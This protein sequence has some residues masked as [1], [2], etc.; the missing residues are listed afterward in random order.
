M[1][2]GSGGRDTGML[3]FVYD[4]YNCLDCKK[5]FDYFVDKIPEEKI[6][7]NKVVCEF[8]SNNNVVAWHYKCPCCAIEME[9]T[10]ITAFWD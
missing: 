3:G 5:T 2:E 6:P 1:F 8:C 7:D 4:T 10:G 9:D